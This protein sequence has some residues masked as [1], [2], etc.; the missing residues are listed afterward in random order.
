MTG[1][2]QLLV[3]WMGSLSERIVI[4]IKAQPNKKITI[5]ILSILTVEV[6]VKIHNRVVLYYF[7]AFY[8]IMLWEQKSTVNICLGSV[9]GN[10]TYRYY[11]LF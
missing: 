7:T 9:T 5:Y 8:T 4:I 11:I 6:Q 3:I 2:W 1:H 10:Q